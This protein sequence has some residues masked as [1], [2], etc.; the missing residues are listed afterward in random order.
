MVFCTNRR[1]EVEEEGQEGK[2][3]FLRGQNVLR[4]GLREG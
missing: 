2:G 3:I 1:K 4:E